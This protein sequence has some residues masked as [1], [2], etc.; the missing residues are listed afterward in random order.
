MGDDDGDMDK[1]QDAKDLP[2]M[3]WS[4]GLVLSPEDIAETLHLEIDKEVSERQVY[5][6]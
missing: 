6:I 2:A 5:N 1:G 3:L 4:L